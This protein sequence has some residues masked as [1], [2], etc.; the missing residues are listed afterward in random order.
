MPDAPVDRGRQK[1]K[2]RRKKQK[3]KKRNQKP[4]RKPQF[5]LGYKF[6]KIHTKQTE[7][8]NESG[9]PLYKAP[10]ALNALWGCVVLL[11]NAPS[12][13]KILKKPKNYAGQTKKCHWT[14]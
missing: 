8:Q 14:L 9:Y 5:Q 11:I 1:Q 13:N 6:N 2:Q 12:R 10:Q 4:K 3:Q 7:S